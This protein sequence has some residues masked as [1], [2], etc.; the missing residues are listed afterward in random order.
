MNGKRKRRR[1]ILDLIAS[2]PIGSQESLG[3]ALSEM[4][5]AAT[6]STLSKD[7]KELGI[8]K[9]PEGRGFRYRAAQAGSPAPFRERMLRREL[10]DFVVE[11]DGAQNVLVVKTLTG[12]AQGVC[13]S[14]DRAD[15][16]E[17]VGTIAGEN[18]IFILVRSD[19][20]REALRTK[21]L[22]MMGEP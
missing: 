12:Y 13:E 15:W 7:I 18:T 1:K 17:V 11:L 2:R 10:T 5:I 20:G 16:E 6:Q 14:I 9:V 19:A 4:G 8:V 3:R 21:I 22:E